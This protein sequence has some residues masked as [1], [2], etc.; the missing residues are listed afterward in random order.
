MVIRQQEREDRSV[1]FWPRSWTVPHFPSE[2]P[3]WTKICRE[4]HLISPTAHHTC[5]CFIHLLLNLDPPSGDRCV[6]L[7]ASVS[8]Q[9]SLS[10]SLCICLLALMA[11]LP[12]CILSLSALYL[13][14]PHSE[15][16][17]QKKEVPTIP[18]N[19]TSPH[20]PQLKMCQRGIR[21]KRDLISRNKK[22]GISGWSTASLLSSY[23][24]PFHHTALYFY[25]HTAL[26][27]H[28]GE[29]KEHVDLSVHQKE[30]LVN[31]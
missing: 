14:L 16:L 13:Y 2:P 17:S 5:T 9:L 31:G 24:F 27:T 23:P 1:G 3:L 28:S 7:P 29:Q 20:Q 11:S 8:Q 6:L 30:L 18:Y 21:R 19:V 25:L 15:F 12:L 22:L 10:L 4:P 26:P